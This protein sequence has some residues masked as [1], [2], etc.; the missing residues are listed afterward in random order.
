M[1][2]HGARMLSVT[3]KVYTLSITSENQ[4]WISQKRYSDFV[5]LDTRV[6]TRPSSSTPP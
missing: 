1:Q 6:R 2:L 4:K 3:P 5:E